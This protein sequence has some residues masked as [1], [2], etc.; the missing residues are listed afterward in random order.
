MTLPVPFFAIRSSLAQP[1]RSPLSAE[2][3]ASQEL[4]RSVPRILSRVIELGSDGS[5]E[6]LVKMVMVWVG[7][8]MLLVYLVVT[9][10]K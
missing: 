7:E 6:I 1:L 3:R 5:R 9:M 10:I 2:R 4:P 8:W